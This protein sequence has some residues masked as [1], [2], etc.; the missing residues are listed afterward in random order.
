M[1]PGSGT[2]RPPQKRWDGSI[3]VLETELRSIK[4]VQSAAIR[5]D[6]LGTFEVEHDGERVLDQACGRIARP[7]DKS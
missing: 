1:K 7:S 4:A 3:P 6:G 2:G 5:I